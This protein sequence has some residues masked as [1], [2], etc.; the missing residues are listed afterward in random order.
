LAPAVRDCQLNKVS[1]IG[2]LSRKMDH[3][4]VSN[5][6]AKAGIDIAAHDALGGEGAAGSQTARTEKKEN[7]RKLRFHRVR[8]C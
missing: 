6:S 3:V 7:A 1:D 4:L 5:P 8:F 2:K